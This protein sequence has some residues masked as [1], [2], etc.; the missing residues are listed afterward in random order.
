M[1]SLTIYDLD[2]AT[3]ERLRMLAAAHDRELE[4]EV[5]HILEQSVRRADREA[6]VA[7]ARKIAA[8]TPAVPQTDSAELMREDRDR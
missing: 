2:E 6:A 8:M 5:R 1:A 3:I 7:R 4:A